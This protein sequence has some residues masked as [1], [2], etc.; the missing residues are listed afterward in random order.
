MRPDTTH[1]VVRGPLGYRAEF[2][3]R[4]TQNKPNE[5]IGWNSK[6]MATYRLQARYVFKRVAPDRTRIEVPDE[7]LGHA[8]WCDRR[9]GLEGDLQVRRRTW[10]RTCATSGTLWR[11]RRP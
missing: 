7:L 9:G 5:P 2:D 4:T 11:V 8:R 10:N 1:W 6:R 3:A